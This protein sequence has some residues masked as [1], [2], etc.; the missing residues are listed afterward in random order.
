MKVLH[1]EA[2]RHLYG[3]ARQVLYL[4]E[5]LAARGVVNGL[6]CPVDS[7]I[8]GHA[9]PHVRDLLAVPMR[10][11]HDLPLI[12]RIRRLIR[13]SRPD[14][15]HLHSR[16]GAD[17]LGGIAARLE[18]CPCVLSRRVDNPEPHWWAGI[19]YRLFDHVITISE[20]I[21]EVLVK[22]GVPGYKVTCVHSAVSARAF[23]HD[24]EREAFNA[25]F[26]VMGGGPVM[27]MIAQMIPRKG[28]RYLLQ[29]LPALAGRFPGLR[30]I[31]F[32]KGPLRRELEGEVAS[33]GLQEFVYF[34]GFRDDLNRWLPCLDLVVHPADME[35]LGVSLLQAAAA[36][37]PLVASRAG[38]IPEIVRHEEN[39][40]LVAPGNTDEL[41]S[42]LDRLLED[43]RLRDIFGTEGRR[44]VQTEF[45]V[46]AMVEG[47]LGVYQ[48]LLAGR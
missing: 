11:D 12:N 10:G 19:K 20:A 5:G 15:V 6:V 3:G 34:A 22:E 33:G 13:E 24:C 31:L 39:G 30:L 18:G 26:G 45:S 48:A 32:G 9:S 23:Q 2:G 35:G 27:A 36:G 40:L 41:L 8:A 28:H 4:L 37:V 16:R 21:R 43:A 38:G 46:D 1:V 25:A 47:N 7:E 44:L 29:V 42:A 14:L 17:L